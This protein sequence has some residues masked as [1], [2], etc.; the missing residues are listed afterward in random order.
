M[1]LLFTDILNELHLSLPK[2]AE[3]NEKEVL[4]PKIKLHIKEIVLWFGLVW[5]GLQYNSVLYLR[6][7]LREF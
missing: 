7:I 5:F 6:G 2:Q 4:N 1:F 3:S